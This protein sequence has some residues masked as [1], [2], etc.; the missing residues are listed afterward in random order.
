M[1]LAVRL[2]KGLCPMRKHIDGENQF[3][4]MNY[5]S[6][7]PPAVPTNPPGKEWL[8]GCTKFAHVIRNERRE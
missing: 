3:N 2:G 1:F 8:V 5:S 6:G 7:L 4:S